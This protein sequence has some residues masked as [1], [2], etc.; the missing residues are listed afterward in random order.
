MARD[1]ADSPPPA[2]CGASASTAQPCR[3]VTLDRPAL[4]A[5]LAAPDGSLPASTWESR[6]HLFSATQVFITQPDLERMTDV[7]HAVEAV[8]R[9]PEYRR[10]VLDRAPAI[11]RA[12]PGPR[13]VFMGYDFHLTAE[14]PRLIEINTNAGGAWLNVA[15]ARA[16]RACCEP[17]RAALRW[18]GA[19]DFDAA[20]RRM[21]AREWSLQRA[22]AG[23]RRIAI[24]DDRP[25]EQFLYPEFVL[26]RRLFEA[27]GIETH[28]ADASQL[29]VRDG[30]LVLAGEPVDLVYNRLT[31]FSLEAAGHA[32]LRRAY[33]SG[34]VVVTPNPHAH[35]LLADKRNLAL[36]SDAAW[37]DAHVPQALLRQA[38]AAIPRTRIVTAENAPALWAARRSLFFKPAGGYGSRGVYRG[39][40]LT[41]GAWAD[42]VAGG[43]V[44]Q[45][46][47]PPSECRV[48]IDGV[49]QRRKLDV[50]LYV[51]D[52]EVLAAAAR[53]YQGQATNFRTPGGGFAP[54]Y[55]V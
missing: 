11:A 47:T 52:G 15:L 41:R 12:D 23:P 22:G 1:P 50:R 25:E 21:F 24:V 45:D 9:L 28:V 35:A 34:S 54:V 5:A 10:A 55:V 7:V 38:L 27:W 20:A 32:A 53:I 8:S 17:V 14:G 13:G 4:I 30:G 26:A 36:L 33:E 18:V 42:V 16:Q 31:D 44:A 19:A 51:Y 2:G 46:W 40:K 37:L 49:E 3:C 6:P 43:Y 29:E 39:E 48:R